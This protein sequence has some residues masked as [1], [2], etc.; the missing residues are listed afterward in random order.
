MTPFHW[1]ALALTALQLADGW[2]TWQVLRLGGR[3]TN[4]AVRWLMERIGAYP[5]LL[6]TKCF[7]AALAWVLALVPTPFEPT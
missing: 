6:L 2:T 5:A 7:A 4:P 3:E 1:L